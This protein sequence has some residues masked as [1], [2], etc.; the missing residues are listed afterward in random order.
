MIADDSL[1]ILFLDMRT[2]LYNEWGG[3][4]ECDTDARFVSCHRNMS[5]MRYNQPIVVDD[6]CTVGILCLTILEKCLD[7]EKEYPMTFWVECMRIFLSQE[8][9]F[10]T[11]IS[12]EGLF[13]SF[14]GFM[15]DFNS[16]YP[17][18][19]PSIFH[20]TREMHRGI[21]FFMARVENRESFII[22]ALGT[23]IVLHH[24]LVSPQNPEEDPHES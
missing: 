17:L 16:T 23:E 3:V 12:L 24:D 2:Q 19:L 18:T 8:F 5:G 22:H 1:E 9:V 20:S 7:A 13:D 14:I 4:F 10:E 21:T 11:E 15:L 6:N